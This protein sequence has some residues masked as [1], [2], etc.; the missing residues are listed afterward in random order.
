MLTPF[1]SHWKLNVP[2]PET[3]AVS[4]T[5]EP[6]STSFNASSEPMLGGNSTS[7]VAS[8]LVTSPTSLPITTV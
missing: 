4:V 3:G 8:M 5:V 1:L 6:G 7:T 2:N